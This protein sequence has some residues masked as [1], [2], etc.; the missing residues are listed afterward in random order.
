MYT[1]VA[2]YIDW[3]ERVTEGPL[4]RARRTRCRGHRSVAQ[5]GNGTEVQAGHRIMASVATLG[6]ADSD[7]QTDHRQ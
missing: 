2:N 5:T 3:I 4:P 1:K 6:V 7:V